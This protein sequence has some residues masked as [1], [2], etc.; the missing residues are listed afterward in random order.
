MHKTDPDFEFK[1]QN[2]CFI[3]KHYYFDSK[4]TFWYL[5]S[6][7][8]FKTDLILK[9]QN[10]GFTNQINSEQNR[11]CPRF[12]QAQGGGGGGGG[13]GAQIHR[14]AL[15]SGFRPIPCAREAS[16]FLNPCISP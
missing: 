3:F 14:F 2:G 1:I 16:P 11:M 9:A 6:F 13:E 7:Y 15:D 12:I 10:S 8:D 4:K 5:L